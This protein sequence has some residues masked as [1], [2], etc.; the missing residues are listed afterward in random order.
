MSNVTRTEFGSGR[1]QM[2]FALSA[3]IL[4]KLSCSPKLGAFMKGS[5]E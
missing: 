4:W 5:S 3:P 2:D 1:L